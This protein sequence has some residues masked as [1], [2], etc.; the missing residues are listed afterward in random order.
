MIIVVCGLAGSGKT[1]VS[2]W[3]SE[4]FNFNC[5]SSDEVRKRIFKHPK[6]TKDEKEAV[7]LKMAHEAA[8]LMDNEPKG[9]IIIDATFS[10]E[11]YRE[12][13]SDLAVKY[14]QKIVFILCKSSDENIKKWMEIRKKDKTLL[15]DADFNVYLKMKKE[16]EPII[17]DLEIDLAD[18]ENEVKKKIEIFLKNKGA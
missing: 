9:N 10:L 12:I 13:I 17:A 6:Y 18:N 15:T 8:S 16:F 7:Y 11:K 2:K 4:K 5:I 1:T 3:I 14:K